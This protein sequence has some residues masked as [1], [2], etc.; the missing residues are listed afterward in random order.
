MNP[1][2][3]LTAIAC[4]AMSLCL[5]RA[6]RA[7]T[8]FCIDPGNQPTSLFDALVAWRDASNQQVTIKVVGGT[9][10]IGVALTQ[11]KDPAASLVLLGGYAPNSGCSEAQRDIVAHETVF[12][13]LGSNAFAIEPAAPVWIDGITFANYYGATVD[14]ANGA[15]SGIHVLAVRSPLTMT[16]FILRHVDGL[17][18]DNNNGNDDQIVLQDCLVVNQPV[19]S[20]QPSVWVSIGH[21]AVTVRNCTIADNHVGVQMDT[22]DGGQVHVFGT[23]AFNNGG[24]DFFTGNV[25]NTPVVSYSFFNTGSGFIGNSNTPVP[26]SNYQVFV[27]AGDYHLAQQSPV[28]NEGDPTLNYSAPLYPGGPN[29]TDLDG[30]ARVQG[31]RVDIGAYESNFLPNQYQVTKTSDDGSS[32][33]LRWAINQANAHP[34]VQS[35]ITFNLGAAAGCP[36]LVYIDSALPDIL[37]PLFIDART[38]PG[39]VANNAIGAFSGALCV[40]LTNG[41]G[42]TLTYGLHV[43]ASATGAQLTAFG[44]IFD[45]M[46]EPILLEGGS[47]HSIGGNRFSGPGLNAIAVG[48]YVTGTA[49]S[50]QIGGNDVQFEN[51]FD[52]SSL[53]AIFLGNASGDNAVLNNLIGVAPD[54]F[55]AMPNPYGVFISGSPRNLVR[56]NYIGHTTYDAV[57][58]TGAGADLNLLQ[59][60]YIGWDFFGPMPNGRYGVFID[61]G[62]AGNIVGNGSLFSF[63]FANTVR[64]SGA[65]GIMITAGAGSGNY[66]LGND[67]VGNGGALQNNGLQ[68][69]DGTLGPDPNAALGPHNFP[70]LRNSFALPN[71]QLMAGMLDAAPNTYYRVDFYHLNTPPVGYPGRGDAGLFAGASPG[72]TLL[73]D[74]NGHC[75][76]LVSLKQVQVGGFMSAAATALG[77]NTSEIGNAVADQLDGIFVDG[78]GPANGCQ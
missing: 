70:V 21:A 29:E 13:G 37:T 68:I 24:D 73:T 61:D 67:L 19:N 38:Q 27:A 11:L 43:P 42:G 66:V 63:N 64:Y 44:M 60:N 9:F 26:S 35:T 34:G 51:V 10:G 77:G 48:V 76:F 36:Y 50:T 8:P 47:N 58:V 31:G 7:D 49:G 57:V 3:I 46:I 2:R 18:V 55:T 30:K 53:A 45:K 78:F 5:P 69:D 52:N 65:A 4:L 72:I 23:I 16:R 71:S 17:L 33:T 14:L 62:A 40:H 20:T 25:V 22:Y 59:Q 15:Y 41:G 32:G 28:I 6:A 74:A 12:D 1:I 75:T 39:W 56:G 54:G